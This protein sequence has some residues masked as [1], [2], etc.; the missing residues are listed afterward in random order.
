ML[1]IQGLAISI[2]NASSA[3]EIKVNNVND[4]TFIKSVV[5][6]ITYL[7]FACRT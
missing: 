1:D 2:A 3:S 7:G 4:I 6:I 5:I